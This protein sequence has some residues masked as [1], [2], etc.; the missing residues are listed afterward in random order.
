MNTWR[1]IDVVSVFKI[2]LCQIIGYFIGVSQTDRKEKSGSCG[3]CIHNR[4]VSDH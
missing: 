1:D 4:P 3:K 2:I